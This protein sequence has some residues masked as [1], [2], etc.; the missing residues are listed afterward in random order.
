MGTRTR[1]LA[2]TIGVGAI[3][4][5]CAPEEPAEI[6]GGFEGDDRATFQDDDPYQATSHVRWREWSPDLFSGRSD[7]P[8]LLDISGLWCHWCH[9]YDV[10]VYGDEDLADFISS[11]FVP[12]RVDPDR[13]PDIDDRYNSGG[14]PTLAVL[15][16]EGDLLDVTGYAPEEVQNFL[17]RAL[18]VYTAGADTMRTRVS[19]GRER[20]ARAEPF[21]REAGSIDPSVL[22]KVMVGLKPYFDL[23]YGGF[24]PPGGNGAKIL[25]PG[26]LGDLLGEVDRNPVVGDDVK[27]FLSRTLDAV[28]DGAIHDPLF[29]G[30]FRTSADRSW[31]QPHFEKL[32]SVQADAIDLYL[33]GHEVWP[34]AGHDRVASSTIDFV[35]D[36]LGNPDG[37]T[38]ANAIDPDRGPGDDGGAYTWT[39]VEVD[40]LLDAR[41]SA[42]AKLA[43]GIARSG[44]LPTRVDAN[45][46]MMA[47]PRDR[48]ARRLELDPTEY[49]RVL[50]EA[51]SRMRAYRRSQGLP[52][53]DVTAYAAPNL[54]VA[55]VLLR[56]AEPL[57]RPELRDRAI[58][59]IDFFTST[60]LGADGLVPHGWNGKTLYTDPLFLENQVAALE[61]LVTAHSV[62]G[63]AAYRDRAMTLLAAT[64]DTFRNEVVGVYWDLPATSSGPGLLAIKRRPLEVNVALASVLMDLYVDGLDPALKTEAEEILSGFTS[65]FGAAGVRAIA[66]AIAVHRLSWDLRGSES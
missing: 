18:Q 32:L 10:V 43:Y 39:V 7:D 12:V 40:S 56:A 8:I 21:L 28:A 63:D 33:R 38:F 20:M 37:V 15:T 19:E 26:A 58:A 62:T 35:L 65:S 30:F 16:P 24:M 55:A 48:G 34:D 57:G 17:N 47:Y 66:Y 51:T 50:D 3:L 61:A 25:A 36:E 5:A 52:R 27:A 64:R 9:V 42:V 44:E 13:R 23:E 54:R 22:E 31:S 49:D 2:I 41:Q 46:L 29:G 53:V 6:P 14:W 45:T 1:I 59:V 4:T 60:H 11:N